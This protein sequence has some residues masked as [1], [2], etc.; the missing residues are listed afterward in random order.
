MLTDAHGRH[1]YAA[2]MK[3]LL[4][5]SGNLQAW[6]L[7]Y[8]AG[9]KGRYSVEANRTD[10]DPVHTMTCPEDCGTDA[11]LSHLYEARNIYRLSDAIVN[12]TTS[13]ALLAGTPEAPFF[14][15]ESIS[16]PFESILSHGLDIP[17]IQSAESVATSP[18]TI[19][20]S[21]PNY[22]HWLIEELPMVLR[23]L[24]AY[25]DVAILAYSAGLTDRHRIAAQTLGID[26]QPAPKTVRVRELVLPG[27]A[28]DSWFVHPRDASLLRDFGSRLAQPS[29]SSMDHLYISRRGASR[30]LPF[31]HELEE[32]LERSG[33]TILAPENLAWP[34]QIA[35]FRNAR[36]IVAPHGAGLSNLVFTEPGARVIELTNGYHYNRCFEWLCHVAGHRYV[37]IG[38]DDG[39]Y[40]GAQEIAEAVLATAL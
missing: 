13:A 38:A 11:P 5:G 7:E 29:T 35:L 2:R 24:N 9:L 1:E 12:T 21:S 36:T 8:R 4:R 10:R 20:P 19:F 27:R 31:E 16:W 33:F 30:S 23:A 17:E 40:S 3:W 25:P 18:V 22:Y 15:R 39:L 14:V 34:E 6:S 28:N 37:P 32:L 26:I